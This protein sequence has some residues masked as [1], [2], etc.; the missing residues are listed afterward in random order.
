[1]LGTIR[2]KTITAKLSASALALTLLAASAGMAGLLGLYDAG[3]SIDE[4][5]S[6]SIA[7]GQMNGAAAA[8]RS[9]YGTGNMDDANL[10][11]TAIKAVRE[12]RELSRQGELAGSL[13]AMEAA[14]GQLTTGW[15]AIRA[16]R[17]R[18][19]AAFSALQTSANKLGQDSLAAIDDIDGKIE[20]TNEEIDN[21]RFV[22][23]GLVD[24]E[25][26]LT[27]A[28]ALLEA[29]M[30]TGADKDR[31]DGGAL[32][33]AAARFADDNQSDNTDES[34]AGALKAIGD[35]V[36]D[37]SA[38]IKAG[39]ASGNL[40]DSWPALSQKF[41]EATQSIDTLVKSERDKSDKLGN[42]LA[43][44]DVKRQSLVSDGSQARQLGEQTDALLRATQLYRL[45]PTKDN[46]AALYASMKTI[47]GSLS[48]FPADLGANLARDF[49][50]F[51]KA[52]DGLVASTETLQVAQAEALKQSQAA[53]EAIRRNADQTAAT[54]GKARNRNM[55]IVLATVCSLLVLATAIM[56]MLRVGIARPI[57]RVTSAMRRLADGHLDVELPPERNDE[58]GAMFRT[59]G[60]FRRNARERE[61][62][63]AQAEAEH[64]ER[65]A[66]VRHV[67]GLIADFDRQVG[68]LVSTVSSNIQ[69]LGRGVTE[70]KTVAEAAAQ[71]ADSATSAGAIA[72]DNISTVAA[73]SQEL[74]VSVRDAREQ[75]RSTS[76]YASKGAGRAHA[77]SHVVSGLSEA[78]SRIGEVVDMIQSIANQ[79]NLLALNATI[80]AARAGE[81]GKGFAVVAGEVKSLAAQTKQLTDDIRSHIASVES[82]AGSAVDLIRT[83]VA[84]TDEIDTAAQAALQSVTRQ[85]MASEEISR[86]AGAAIDS[87]ADLAGQT[88]ALSRDVARTQ[89]V[90][91][92]LY[93]TTSSVASEIQQLL[94]LIHSFTE[95]VRAA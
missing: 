33:D 66:R 64:R 71:R 76:E 88:E 45:E 26:R 13:D 52:A 28:S 51:A 43:G 36:A 40:R 12:G 9:L 54:A 18:I 21:N 77:A 27:K 86:S 74:A 32:A 60:I 23:T 67:A 91:E 17:E 19:N 89:G 83:I 46:E 22:L 2:L 16:E 1:M 6:V 62:L 15:D 59:L 29:H 47:E 90:A 55:G 57:Q 63:H 38:G 81:A 25:I 49:K 10:A 42:R 61:D 72:R 92:G 53:M 31:I 30:R 84:S 58:I 7:M 37:L 41:A 44:L 93:E 48:A 56:L 39:A 50:S 82:S 24:T 3:R 69:H 80:E 95:A 8:V 79:T 65:D 87:T 78:T 11:R 5:S 35:G 34:I 70:I 68:E 4:L 14:V 73:S 20:T 85:G 75:T 94:D